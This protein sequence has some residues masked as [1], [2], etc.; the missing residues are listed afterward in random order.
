VLANVEQLSAELLAVADPNGAAQLVNS[1]VDQLA[2]PLAFLSLTSR[3]GTGVAQQL[4]NAV[5]DVA[6][7]TS[8]AA[9]GQ[10]LRA[11]F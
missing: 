7:A 6:H 3:E 4:L 9:P 8:T 10:R 1:D 2:D 5:T 11:Y